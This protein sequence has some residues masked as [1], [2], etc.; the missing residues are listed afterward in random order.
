MKLLDVFLLYPSFALLII[1]LHQVI[2]RSIAENSFAKER[3]RT[4]LLDSDAGL[5]VFFH[6]PMAAQ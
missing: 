6:L 5:A 4:E 3:F 1:G 2:T